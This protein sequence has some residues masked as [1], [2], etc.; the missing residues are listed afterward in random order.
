MLE[1][2]D[3]DERKKAFILELDDVIYPERDYLL[4]VYYLFANFIE[5]SEGAPS[6]RDLVEFMK[7]AYDHHGDPG[8]FER[9]HDAFA[10]DK[11]YHENFERLYYTAR[12]PLKLLMFDKILKLLQE[13]IVDRKQIFIVTNGPAAVQLN[14]ITQTEWNGLEKYVHVYYAEE[15]K[16]KP[17]P[18]VLTYILSRHNLQR[19]DILMIGASKVDEEFAAA[20]GTD[21]LHV[22]EFL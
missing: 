11:K 18:D 2:K 1:Y 19:K 21:Y 5:F 20:A 15:T 17:E 10:V 3:L 22:S 14:K 9:V 4:Q 7:T 16:P 13:I 6:A 8:M 12:L